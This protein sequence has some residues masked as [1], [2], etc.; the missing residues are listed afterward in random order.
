MVNQLA[1][2]A[3]FISSEYISMSSKTYLVVRIEQRNWDGVQKWV[4]R[5]RK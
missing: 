3:M 4:D 5:I 2:P 1:R